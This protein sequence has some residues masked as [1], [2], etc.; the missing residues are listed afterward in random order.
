M[1][2]WRKALIILAVAYG[3][4]MPIELVREAMGI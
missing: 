1:S 4:E 3:Q 2:K